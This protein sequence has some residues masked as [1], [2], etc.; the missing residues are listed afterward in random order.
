MNKLACDRNM[1][2]YVMQSMQVNMVNT[3]LIWGCQVSQPMER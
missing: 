1:T 2:S 3:W